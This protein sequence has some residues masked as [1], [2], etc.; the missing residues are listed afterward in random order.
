MDELDWT[1]L[2]TQLAFTGPGLTIRAQTYRLPDGRVI[3]P[4]YLLE[5]DTWVNVVAL[6]PD[7]Q[8]LLVR[9]FRY[10][11]GRTLL[12][13]PGGVM[14]QDDESPEAA[15]RRELLEETG[16]TAEQFIPVGVVSPNP[17]NQS[18]LCHTFLALNA[19]QVQD[20][21]LD[22]SEFLQVARMPLGEAVELAQKGGFLQAMHVSALFF[23]LAHLGWVNSGSA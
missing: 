8:V 17:A 16:C 21:N 13:V 2:A 12:E 18:N 5:Y 20:L 4:C 6:T 11:I 23:A 14:E 10:G 19:V 3:Q 15:A 7:Q 9:Q 22:E 1:L